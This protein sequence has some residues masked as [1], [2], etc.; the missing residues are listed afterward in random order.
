MP[1]T[2]QMPLPERV[3]GMPM[4]GIEDRAADHEVSAT[5]LYRGSTAATTFR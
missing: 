5:G 3:L 4:R 2:R 1:L